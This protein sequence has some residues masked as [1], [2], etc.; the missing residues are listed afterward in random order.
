MQQTPTQETFSIPNDTQER[1]QTLIKNGVFKDLQNFTDMAITQFLNSFDHAKINPKK[2]KK[3]KSKFRVTCESLDE[4]IEDL[5]EGGVKG[6][7]D[8]V[9]VDYERVVNGGDFFMHH[10]KKGRLNMVFEVDIYEENSSFKDGERY[11][12]C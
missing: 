1:I 10:M 11:I 8:A 6:H 4:L 12:Y 3:S 9:L 5:R 2:A 7:F